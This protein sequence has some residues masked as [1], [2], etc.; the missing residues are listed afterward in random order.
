M[1]PIHARALR[2]VWGMTVG[3]L[4]S[5]LMYCVV[6]YQVFESRRLALACSIWM[7]YH[8]AK[9]LQKVWT[10]YYTEKEK[11]APQVRGD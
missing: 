10:V 2:I 3:L 11:Y 1:T 5:N 8:G 7:G 4:A 6:A 9:I